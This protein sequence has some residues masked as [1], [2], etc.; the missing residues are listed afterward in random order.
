MVAGRGNTGHTPNNDAG[1][2]EPSR[3]TTM[4]HSASISDG[5]GMVAENT[6]AN[7][8]FRHNSEQLQRANEAK[9]QS[10][11]SEQPAKSADLSFA[12]DR[13]RGDYNL[14]KQEQVAATA[15]ERQNNPDDAGLR[16]VKD[17]GRANY[18]SL[19]QEPADKA[20][21]GLTFAKD[22]S[23]DIDRGR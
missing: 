2:D 6:N 3:P 11:S 1:K 13:G 7:A 18:A 20:D 21:K 10:Q 8:R 4:P 14:L 12:K 5:A 19:K 16:F 23:Q 17:A 22:K 15:P 9:G